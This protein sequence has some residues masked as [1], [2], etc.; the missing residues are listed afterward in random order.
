MAK[1]YVTLG[2]LVREE[3]TVVVEAKSAN[4]VKERLHDVYEEYDGDWTEDVV[5]GCEESDSH[6]F[7]GDAPKNAKANVTLED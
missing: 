7:D 4:E 3:A 5:W 1:F 2:R 6:T